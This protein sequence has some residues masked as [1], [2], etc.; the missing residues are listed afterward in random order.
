MKKA[1]PIILCL[2]H[3]LLPLARAGG[4][5]NTGCPACVAEKADGRKA[6]PEPKPDKE[7]EAGGGKERPTADQDSSHYSVNKFNFLFY[8]IYKMKY[9]DGGEEGPPED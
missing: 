3:G 4:N 2:L 9:M 8:L 1:L 6:D 5:G 7:S